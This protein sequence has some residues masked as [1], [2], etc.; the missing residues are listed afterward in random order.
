M[1]QARSTPRRLCSVQ[2]PLPPV[3]AAAVPAQAEPR[4]KW[5]YRHGRRKNPKE[6]SDQRYNS[7]EE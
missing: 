1:P 5:A 7:T 6:T 3:F 2:V 4:V